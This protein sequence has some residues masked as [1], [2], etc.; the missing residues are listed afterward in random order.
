MK[1]KILA[2]KRKFRLKIAAV[3]IAII[4]TTILTI[5][6]DSSVYMFLLFIFIFTLLVF[7][8]KKREKTAWIYLFYSGI[9]VLPEND[10]EL[11]WFPESGEQYLFKKD[12]GPW[13]D[14]KY[15]GPSKDPK[16]PFCAR[17]IDGKTKNFNRVMPYNSDFT[18]KTS[19]PSNVQV[20][21][22][23]PTEN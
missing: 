10:R 15:D 1:N 7:S 18:G 8:I 3:I 20:I 21:F 16:Y 19:I 9:E 17:Y 6:S 2:K 23:I 12:K 4:L 14:W 22:A 11:E 13:L 5:T